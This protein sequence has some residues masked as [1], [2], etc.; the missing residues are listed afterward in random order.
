MPFGLCFFFPTGHPLGCVF[1][2]RFT[3]FVVIIG[4]LMVKLYTNFNFLCTMQRNHAVFTFD[5][6]LMFDSFQTSN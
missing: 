5:T 6:A 3:I 1:G 4:V 2:L